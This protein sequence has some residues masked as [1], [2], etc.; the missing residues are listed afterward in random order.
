MFNFS[1]DAFESS[2]GLIDFEFDVEYDIISDETG[3]EYDWYAD[4]SIGVTVYDDDGNVTAELLL[5]SEDPLSQE[6]FKHYNRHI[7]DL[8]H[9]D[10]SSSW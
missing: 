6:I 3:T 7:V 9:D 1:M 8:C 2:I 5:K 4:S 10:Y